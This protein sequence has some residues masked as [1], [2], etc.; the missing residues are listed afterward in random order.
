MQTELSE[1]AEWHIYARHY[2]NQWC[3]SLVTLA[4]V[5]SPSL[6]QI[7]ACRLFAAKPLYEPVLD[8]IVHETI[9]NK[10]Q[11]N[12]NQNITIFCTREL[13][14]KCRL[15]N[16]RHFVST[17]MSHGSC[18]VD[19]RKRTLWEIST[20]RFALFC[21]SICKLT[22]YFTDILQGYFTCTGAIARLPQCQWNNPEE[23]G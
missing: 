9:G 1:A 17:W 14:W 11:W 16:G 2:L 13:A 15:Q 12:C 19:M 7:M 22:N 8:F 10:F 20:T 6:V 5:S 3:P 18:W 21:V 23:C 4:S